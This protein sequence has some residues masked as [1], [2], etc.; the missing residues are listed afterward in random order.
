M[1]GGQSFDCE[2]ADIAELRSLALSFWGPDTLG[3]AFVA[4]EWVDAHDMERFAVSDPS[5]RETICEVAALTDEQTKAAINS[6]QIA[7]RVWKGKLP[8]ER[9]EILM[10]WHDLILARLRQ[11]A[12]LITYEQ[13][14]PLAEAEAEV[15]YGASF[16]RWFAAEASR[17]YGETIPSHLPRRKLITQYEPLGVVALITPWN[18]P[19]AMLA[20]KAA[21]ALAAGCTAVSFPSR[22]TPLSALALAA[23]AE[24]AGIP[25]GVFSVLTGDSRKIVQLL[26][27][28]HEV[29]GVSFT[30]STEVGRHIAAMCAPSIKRVSLELGGHAPFIVFPD[31]DVD[32]AAGAALEAKF[33][34]SGQDCLAANRIFVHRSCYDKFIAAF[35]RKVKEIKV[36]AGYEPEVTIGPLIHER[37]RSRMVGQ[38]SDAVSRGAQVA[39]GGGN[40]ARGGLFFEPTVL[41]NVSLDME[42]CR[43]ETF[44]P[45]AAILPFEDE[46]QLTEAANNTHFGLAAYLYTN[47]LSRAM[48]LANALEFGMVAINSVQ[49]TGAPIPF[50]G[51]K[52]SGLGREGSRHGM[53]EFSELKYICIAH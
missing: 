30:G 1:M 50:G 33:Q 43:E 46:A 51:T 18:F 9:A 49:F 14:K 16:I 52:Q 45:V 31:I 41:T 27:E 35:V 23:L 32:V 6:A 29:R 42:I 15:A 8:L 20:R 17:Q 11:F 22:E 13:G 28:S 12:A 7:A 24:E 38:I 44:G 34:T 39:L 5:T 3:R 26:C 2:I 25:S 37:A 36:G 10:R 19:M 21:A 40:H 4:G 48:R 53:Q 47:D